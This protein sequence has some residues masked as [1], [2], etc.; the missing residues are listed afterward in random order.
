MLNDM[1]LVGRQMRTERGPVFLDVGHPV[2][3]QPMWRVEP[4]LFADAVIKTLAQS[5][6]N[7]VHDANTVEGGLEWIETW[8]SLI[9]CAVDLRYRDLPV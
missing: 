9:N 7:T 2:T 3:K 1:K 4:C 5:D 8:M 6:R